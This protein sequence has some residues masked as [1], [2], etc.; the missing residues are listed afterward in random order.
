MRRLDGTIPNQAGSQIFNCSISSTV[1]SQFR[2]WKYTSV[3]CGGILEKYRVGIIGLG[4]MGWSYDV[5]LDR[6]FAGET[7][8]GGT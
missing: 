3:G 2:D 6:A 8:R 4:W 1:T 5:A 7:A